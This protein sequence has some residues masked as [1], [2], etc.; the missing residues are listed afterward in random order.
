MVGRIIVRYFVGLLVFVWVCSHTS[1][2]VSLCDCFR[3]SSLGASR[4]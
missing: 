2:T 4:R 1:R 3:Y